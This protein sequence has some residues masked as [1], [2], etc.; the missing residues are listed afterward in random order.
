MANNIIKT[1]EIGATIK[2]RRKALCLSQEEL[3]EKVG[4]TLHQ[5]QRYE[6][7]RTILNVENVQRIADILGLPVEDFFASG[8]P[9]TVAE[10]VESYFTSDEKTLLRHYRSITKVAKRKMAVSV[11]KLLADKE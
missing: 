1:E 5:M 10:S 2:S 3:A 11:V 4:V 8:R 6:N 9:E 7:G